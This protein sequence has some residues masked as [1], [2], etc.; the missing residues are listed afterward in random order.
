M[1]REL[2]SS[3][4]LCGNILQTVQKADEERE[5]LAMQLQ[6]QAKELTELNEQQFNQAGVCMHNIM[7][8]ECVCVCVC[9]CACVHVCVCV[10]LRS[11]KEGWE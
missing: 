5:Q 8:V 2:E 1:E 9:A 7:Y 4:A 10:C 6:V 11:R 3:V